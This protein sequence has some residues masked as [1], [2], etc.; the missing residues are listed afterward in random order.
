VWR[1]EEA[2]DVMSLGP[3]MKGG[4]N[5]L[6]GGQGHGKRHECECEGLTY[7]NIN[8][9]GSGRPQHDMQSSHCRPCRRLFVLR[10]RNAVQGGT[11]KG[12]GHGRAEQ[13]E[14]TFKHPGSRHP[15]WWKMLYSH[16]LEL[17][18]MIATTKWRWKC[19]K[20]KTAR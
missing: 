15:F 20:S 2:I 12:W 13:D 14:R 17:Q 19:C 4:M 18:S 6:V 1:S 8:V 7:A 11:K 5:V 9:V 16:L 10:H 3:M